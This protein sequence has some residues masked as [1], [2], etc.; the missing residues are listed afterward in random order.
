ME[1]SYFT[2]TW[3]NYV[4]NDWSGSALTLDGSVVYSANTNTITNDAADAKGL[5]VV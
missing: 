5:T 1:G 3:V 4:V 2:P